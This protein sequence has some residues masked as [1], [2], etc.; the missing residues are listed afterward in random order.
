MR[1]ARY[2]TLSFE[3]TRTV[4]PPLRV[5]DGSRGPVEMRRRVVP[6]LAALVGVVGVIL[7]IVCANLANLLLARASSRQQ[8]IA[9]RLAIGAGRRR[10][11][12]Q[13]MT[14]SMLLA[15]CGGLL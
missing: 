6:M 15:L 4:V 5:N 8:E 11:I 10:L 7:L 13:L 12:R 3:A 2:R 14:E 1:P 9:V